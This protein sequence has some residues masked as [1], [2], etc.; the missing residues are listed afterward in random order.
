[1]SLE[2]RI[3]RLEERAASPEAA[4]EAHD[5]KM[6]ALILELGFAT[7]AEMARPFDFMAVCV[8]FLPLLQARAAA[9][10]ACLPVPTKL[11]PAVEAS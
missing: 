2:S 10:A 4:E 8:R 7:E 3:R 11:P 9:R 5:A 6:R 1:M